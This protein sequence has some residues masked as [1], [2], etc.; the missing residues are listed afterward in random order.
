MTPHRE[1]QEDLLSVVL[2]AYNEEESLLTV[3]ERILAIRPALRAATP[4]LHRIELIVVDD[5]STDRTAVI[6]RSHP[7]VVLIRHETNQ[8]YGRA[9]KTGFEAAHG[10]TL[11]FLDADGTYPPEALPRL[12]RVLARRRADLVIGTRMTQRSRAMPWERYLGNRLFAMLLSW[13]VGRRVTD[14]ASGM[15]VFRREVLPRLLPLPDGLHLTPAMSARAFHEG[16]KIV[17]VPIRYEERAGRSKLN[18][19]T[20]GLRFLNIILRI[21]NRYNPLKL[22]GALGLLMLAV[23]FWLGLDPLAYYV[24]VG[25]VEDTEIYRLFTIMVLTVTGLN[26]LTFGA[27]A[28]SVVEIVRGRELPRPGWLGHVLSRTFIRRSGFFGSALIVAA[29][30]LNHQAI[31]EYVTTGR[32]YVHWAYVLTGAMLFLVGLQ[33]VMGSVLIGIL[34]DVKASQAAREEPPRPRNS[35]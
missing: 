19:L 8:G 11:A 9:L 2:P 24:T 34:Q 25:R 20:D 31:V 30:L 16:L 1:I 23:G 12:C 7:E 6:A 15:R 4:T 28:N 22:F 29:P 13:V 10:G 3:V 5:G 14:T 26:L 35:H 21:A 27:L 33:L 32:I 17:E 18:P